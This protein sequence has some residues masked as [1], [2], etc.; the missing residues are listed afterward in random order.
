MVDVM[1][2]QIALDRGSAYW[3]GEPHGPTLDA[4]ETW[5]RSLRDFLAGGA[6]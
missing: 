1:L 6:S 4:A 5:L 2:H 3:T